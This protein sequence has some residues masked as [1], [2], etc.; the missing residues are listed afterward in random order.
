MRL[1]NILKA[2]FVMSV[3]S[4]PV[5]AQDNYQLGPDSMPKADVQ[6]GT[7]THYTW[8][9][10]VYPGTVRDYWVYVPAQYDATKRT[11]VMVFQDGGGYQDSNGGW[12]VP[13]VF[14]NLIAS[15]EMPVTIAIMINP[16]VVPPANANALPRY[17]RSV[18]YDTPSGK[19]ADFLEQEILPEVSKKY[20]LS[21]NP[22]DR[23]ISGGSSGGICA[24]TTAWERPDLFSRVVSFIGSFTNL[25]GGHTFPALIRETEPKPLRIF[26]QD[27]SNDQDIYS[28]SWFI[29][30]QDVYAALKFARYDCK[31]E[32]GTGSHSGRH[33]GAILPDALRWVWRGYP[34]RIEPPTTTPQPILNIVDTNS[35]W[36]GLYFH[37]TE[38][39]RQVDLYPSTFAVDKEGDAYISL[40]DLRCILKVSSTEKPYTFFSDIDVTSVAMGPDGLLYAADIKKRRIVKID[41]NRGDVGSIDNLP[42]RSIAIDHQRV[43]Y[44]LQDSGTIVRINGKQRTTFKTGIVNARSIQLSPDQTLLIVTQLNPSNNAW[45]YQIGGPKGLQHKEMFYDI[46]VPYT[47]PNSPVGGMCV[48][49]NGWLYV[50]TEM[51]IQMIDQAGR[52]NGIMVGPERKP[53]RAVVLGGPN[54]SKMY[55]ETTKGVYVRDTK[56]RGVYSWMPPVK[57]A[58]PRL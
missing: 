49:A 25:R 2:W 48:D 53:I 30:N 28:G 58:S 50:A 38:A 26:L 10:T 31:F 35:E 6:K 42:C 11:C 33:G 54:S 9:S 24:F 40:N 45:S 57:P 17:N 5:F 23:A 8:T 12:R 13:V 19:Y 16:G 18:E 34:A 29:G 15:H 43:I 14:D 21:Q 46:H 3:I 55:V 52:V 41:Q 39:K 47:H 44:A 36:T 20:N 1:Q 37:Q 32:I 7:T 51:G 27:G 4:S 22:N 56:A